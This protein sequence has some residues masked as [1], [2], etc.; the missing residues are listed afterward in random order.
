MQA[1]KCRTNPATVVS[2]NTDDDPACLADVCDPKT[3][4]CKEIGLPKDGTACDDA[5][6]CTGDDCHPQSGCFHFAKGGACTLG[7]SCTVLDTCLAGKCVAGQPRLFSEQLVA[8]AGLPAG[9]AA[10]E[11]GSVLVGSLTSK[12]T[13]R[14]LSAAGAVLNTETQADLPTF[15]K[16]SRMTR[17]PDGR[18]LQAAACGGSI[19]LMRFGSD[20]KRDLVSSQ[21]MLANSSA[22]SLR[23]VSWRNLGG[24]LQYLTCAGAQVSY[25]RSQ[26]GVF[27]ER[28]KYLSKF[29]YASAAGHN[30]CAGVEPLDNTGKVVMV[31]STTADG[32]GAH[33]GA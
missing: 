23:A 31:S 5:N 6:P 12:L 30:E 25:L 14:R 4:K 29:E 21:V 17:L 10:L 16:V 7:K 24:T 27:D 15:A 26:I 11:D 1:K 28:G 8:S 3:G 22:E 33:P 13:V 18:V 9:M 20:G 2:C 19:Y 32:I